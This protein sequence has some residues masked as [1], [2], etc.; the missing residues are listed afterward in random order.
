MS[1]H[2][3]LF[4]LHAVSAP[5]KCRHSTGLWTYVVFD[6]GRPG[7]NRG[8]LGLRRFLTVR[9]AKTVKKVAERSKALLRVGVKIAITW[10]K[11][12]IFLICFHYSVRT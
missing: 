6:W 1:I 9:P 10:S 8:P 11:I 7:S 4:M 5:I 3:N 2:R 12:N